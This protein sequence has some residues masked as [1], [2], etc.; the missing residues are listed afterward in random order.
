M[1]KYRVLIRG[2]DEEGNHSLT[3]HIITT[4]LNIEI[5]FI[6]LYGSGDYDL[7]SWKKI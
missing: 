1:E 7:V 4:D 6:Q 5:W 2:W 3:S